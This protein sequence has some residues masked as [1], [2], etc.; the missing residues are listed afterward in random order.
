MWK[1][2][3]SHRNRSIYQA[4]CPYRIGIST[5]VCCNNHGSTVIE[6]ETHF[7]IECDYYSDRR[8]YLFNTAA[9]IKD[10]CD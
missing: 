7:I 6:D 5:N 1:P 3:P 4:T 9:D 2:A 8:L 10:A